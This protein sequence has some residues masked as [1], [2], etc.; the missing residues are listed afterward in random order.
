MHCTEQEGDCVTKQE[1]KEHV[2]EMHLQLG[3]TAGIH[4]TMQIA[5]LDH[6]H[7]LY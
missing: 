5:A 2:Y 7:I 1:L 4:D 6:L 3:I